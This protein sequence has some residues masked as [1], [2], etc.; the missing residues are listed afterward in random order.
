MILFLSTAD[1]D[2]LTLSHALGELPEA[3]PT[4]R[5]TNP[6]TLN[7][8]EMAGRYLDRELPG[9]RVVVLRL[10][11]GK[12]AFEH[13]FDRL[14][15][16]CRDREVPVV[17]VPGDQSPDPE[18]QAATTADA[19]V[20]STVFEYLLHGGVANVGNCLRLL[21]DRYLGT[22]LGAEPPAEL[23]WEGIYHP[24]LP[25]GLSVEAYLGHR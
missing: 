17:A 2:L 24:D 7:S 11:G 13:G 14:V 21:A 9:A 18:L 25:D 5:A 6:A 16:E 15:A 12:R 8:P 23:P 3:F 1:T 19:D 22:S 10:L 4:V 20:V